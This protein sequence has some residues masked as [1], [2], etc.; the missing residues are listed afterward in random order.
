[1]IRDVGTFKLIESLC[2]CV[3]FVEVNVKVNGI[4]SLIIL[5]IYSI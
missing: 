5:D 2:Y 3:Y 4:R 1:M